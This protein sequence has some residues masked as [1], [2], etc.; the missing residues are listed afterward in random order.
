MQITTEYKSWLA[1]VK[2]RIK[3]ARIKASL[4]ANAELILFYWDL[5]KMIAEKQAQTNWGDKLIGQVA[6]DLFPFG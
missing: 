3:V 6:N 1:E 5:G 2:D 4:A